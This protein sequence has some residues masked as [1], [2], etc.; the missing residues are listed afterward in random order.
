MAGNMLAKTSQISIK[1]LRYKYLI[2]DVLRTDFPS[3]FGM[4]LKY[5]FLTK[6]PIGV[7]DRIESAAPTPSRIEF[8]VHDAK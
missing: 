1:K 8:D 2:Y 3:Y 4:L 6:R 7:F 5:T